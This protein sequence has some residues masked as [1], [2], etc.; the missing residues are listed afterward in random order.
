MGGAG[1]MFGGIVGGGVFGRGLLNLLGGLSVV[2]GLASMGRKGAGV[3]DIA[4]GL[5][6]LAGSGLFNKLLGFG[7]G[8]M[9]GNVLRITPPLTV[10]AAEV[11]QA[12]DILAGALA[13]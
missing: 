2:M 8:G 5:F 7:K 13:A 10:S 3:G 4:G 11:D 9:F 1:G 6:G 12:L